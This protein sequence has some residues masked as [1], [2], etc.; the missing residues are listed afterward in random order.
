LGTPMDVLTN[1][2]LLLAYSGHAQL[3]QAADGTTTLAD[4]CCDGE[5][6]NE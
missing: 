5:E 4:S 3:I 2:N 1:E 6:E